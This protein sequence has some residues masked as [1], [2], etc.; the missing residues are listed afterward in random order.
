MDAVSRDNGPG[1]KLTGLR[2]TPWYYPFS[3]QPTWCVWGCV[4]EIALRK[5]LTSKTINDHAWIADLEL[6][7]VVDEFPCL[8]YLHENQPRTLQIAAG[9]FGRSKRPIKSRFVSANRAVWKL[10]T[11]QSSWL[12]NTNRTSRSK[13]KGN[14]ESTPVDK[15]QKNVSCKVPNSQQIWELATWTD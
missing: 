12:K 15:P 1:P 7:P 8:M 4:V 6:F 13:K 3:E 11:N 9:Q 14:G 2:K 10:P 5:L